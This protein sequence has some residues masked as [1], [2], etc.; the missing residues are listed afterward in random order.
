MKRVLLTMVLALGLAATAM[1]EAQWLT[2]IKAAREQAAKEKKPVF[3]L[4]TGSDW[5]PG[6]IHMHKELFSKKI[7]EDFAAKNVILMKVD[8]PEKI[9]LP[10]EVEK[11]NEELQ[12]QYKVEGYPTIIIT[13]KDG[14]K[15]AESGIEEYGL[16]NNPAKYI[17]VLEK[18]IGKK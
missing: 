3:M 6:C 16:I 1:A 5:C 4:F 15:I 10:A 9:K 2:D 11:Q 8:F 17:K 18:Q 14:K 12:L 13:D 7:F